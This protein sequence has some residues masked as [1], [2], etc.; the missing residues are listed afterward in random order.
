MAND[1]ATLAREELLH[2]AAE[3]R[4]A[5]DDITRAYRA[6]GVATERGWDSRPRGTDPV[7]THAR[8]LL[9]R[10]PAEIDRDV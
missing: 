10:C 7:Y 5:L 1:Q 6:F 3:L 9:A 8:D 4:M 2:W